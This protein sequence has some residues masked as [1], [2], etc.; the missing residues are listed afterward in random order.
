MHLISEL[1]IKSNI[2]AIIVIRTL[3]KSI[4]AIDIIQKTQTPSTLSIELTFSYYLLV[5]FSQEKVLKV[6]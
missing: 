2:Y 4:K 6:L 1:K 3:L 5:N